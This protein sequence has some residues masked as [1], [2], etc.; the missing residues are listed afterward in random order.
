MNS[1]ENA[2][3]RNLTSERN[4][5]G[6]GDLFIS[7]CGRIGHDFRVEGWLEARN[8]KGFLRG[9]F[10]SEAS[11]KE[12]YPKGMPGWAALVG[13]TLPAD[14]YMWIGG[15]WVNTGKKG[16]APVAELESLKERLEEAAEVAQKASDDVAELKKEM[17]EGGIHYDALTDGE[18][19]AA[20]N[21]ALNKESASDA[22]IQDKKE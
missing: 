18:I 5:R 13:D 3:V 19:A 10:E 2:N 14:V 22:V 7:G 21:A 4:I 6:G 20:A 12:H 16:G 15:E 8:I 9:L 11:L 1:E 17:S